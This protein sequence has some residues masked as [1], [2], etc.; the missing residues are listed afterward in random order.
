[1]RG[2]ERRSF[3]A[4]IAEL[5]APEALAESRARPDETNGYVVLG[6]YGRLLGGFLDV[7]PRERLLV[8]FHGDLERDPAAVC[9]AAFG[10]LGVD[11]G[12]RPP[13][14][15]RR[16]HDGGSRRRSAWLDLT[17]W[18][19]AARRSAALSALW[20]RAPRSLRLRVLRRFNLASRRLFLW[21]RV[22]ADPAAGPDPVSE[23]TRARLRAHYRED[24][25]R[26]QALL[27]LDLPW[28]PPA[29]TGR[30]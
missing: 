11:A 10:F 18:Q 13:N 20:R 1:M 6:E 27:G 22:P 24:G 17:E 7:F 15:G 30:R 5:L 4:A 19:R 29:P 21:N 12:F 14:L 25:Q 23:E 2:I 3:D 28:R 9:A 26:L 16:Y 8:L